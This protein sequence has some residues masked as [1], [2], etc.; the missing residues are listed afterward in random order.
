MIG[1]NRR[2]Q[3][4][5]QN[6]EGVTLS[7]AGRTALVTGGSRGI[8]TATV[9]LMRRAGA[10]VVFSYQS[11]SERAEALVAECGGAMVCRAVKQELGSAEEGEALVW[12]AVETWGLLDILVVNHG[13]WPAHDQPIGTMPTEQWRRTMGINLDSTFGLVR[14]ATTQMLRQEALAENQVKGHV[15][16][17]ASTAAQRG[18]AFHADY[19]ASKG[20]MVSLTKSLSSELAPQGIL[21]NCV[22][23]GWVRTEMSSAALDDPE[24]SKR[25]LGLIPLGRAGDVDEIAGPI[26]FLCTRWAG[27]VSGEIF[28]VN[29]GAVLVG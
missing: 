16:L 12:T 22:A 20:A 7:L 4:V 10:R 25:A 29:G 17:V 24:T 28:N 27:F 11:Q 23:P 3:N 8:G 2:M 1:V 5:V 14:A 6:G 18:E 13:V 21:C 9:R 19:A 26:V 15:V